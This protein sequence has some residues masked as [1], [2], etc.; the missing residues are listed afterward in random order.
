MAAM[1]EGCREYGI[2]GRFRNNLGLDAALAALAGGRHA[3]FG[4]DELRALGLSTSAVHKRTASG[5]LH[6]C[7]RGVYSV[8]PLPLLTRK[9]H[10]MAAA[11]ACGPGAVVSHVQAAALHGLRPTEASRIHVTVPGG[12]RRCRRTIWVH[13]SRV[14]TPADVTTVEGIPC[15][16]VARTL[17]DI[18]E[19]ISRRGLERA[20][21]SSETLELFDLGAIEDQL[22]RNP[23]RAGARKVRAVLDEHYI[24]STVTESELEEA[25]LALCRRI[26]IPEPQLQ[27]WLML[28]DGGPPIRADFLWRGQRVVV[29]VD[30]R[31]FHRTTQAVP[32]DGRRDQRLTVHG[33]RP[34]RTDG[35]Q[36]FQ[37]PAELEAPLV[38]LLR[39]R[40]PAR[41]A[42]PRVARG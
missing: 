13:R 18:S 5:R 30:G 36:I 25:F 32:R 40:R 8:V 15:T 17:F 22:E 23:T 38:A 33:W 11:L 12:G 35:H 6:R 37:R 7:H 3:V 28:P 29:E 27:Q 20:F 14:L 34:I 19:M 9:G 39:P 2:Y 10:W 41:A 42:G 21:D 24:G 31:R 26:D 4:L 1:G 16:S